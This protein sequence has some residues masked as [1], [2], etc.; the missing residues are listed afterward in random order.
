M[1]PNMHQS[2]N[3]RVFSRKSFLQLL[4]ASLE[5]GSYRFARQASLNWLAVFPGDLTIQLY[6]GKAHLSEG[7]LAQ[8]LPVVERV[9]RFDPEYFEAQETL[10]IIYRKIDSAKVSSSQAAS[11]IL[12]NAPLDSTFPEWV[13]WHQAAR[14]AMEGGNLQEADHLLHQVMSVVPDFALAAIDHLN[15]GWQQRDRSTL[16]R[17]FTV[18]FAPGRSGNRFW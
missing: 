7:K 17:L 8:A 11:A 4:E 18:C 9:C 6:L 5:S 3:P 1:N 12:S 14:K 15:F 2:I 16:A 10:S 13:G